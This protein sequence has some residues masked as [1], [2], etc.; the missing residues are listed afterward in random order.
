MSSVSHFQKHSFSQLE[1]EEYYSNDQVFIRGI[2]TF[3]ISIKV[4]E[5]DLKLM[6]MNFFITDEVEQV[7]RAIEIRVVALDSKVIDQG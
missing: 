7:I 1:Q 6:I 2:E 5:S 4:L 3:I